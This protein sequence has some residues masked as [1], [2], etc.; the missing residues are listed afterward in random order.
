MKGGSAAPALS[1]HDVSK[2]ATFVEGPSSSLRAEVVRADVG[3]GRL[4]VHR[5]ETVFDNR[6][7]PSRD[8]LF[9]GFLVRFPN[10]NEQR[11]YLSLYWLVA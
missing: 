6:S 9:G 4:D 10:G 3:S 11:V 2:R 5:D 8:R 7:D 1:F